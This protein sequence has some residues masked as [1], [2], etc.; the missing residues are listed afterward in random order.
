[1]P[2]SL[3]DDT[4][5]GATKK[6]EPLEHEFRQNLLGDGSISSFF[7]HVKKFEFLGKNASEGVQKRLTENV[8]YGSSLDDFFFLSKIY[9][10]S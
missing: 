2:P 8:S 7:V 6:H 10:K 3:V 1:M 4:W 5:R 9:C